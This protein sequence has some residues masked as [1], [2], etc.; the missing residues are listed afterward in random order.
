M[1]TM[2]F[3]EVCQSRDD[4]HRPEHRRGEHFGVGGGKGRSHRWEVIFNRPLTIE[5]RAI[6]RTGFVLSVINTLRDLDQQLL[7]RISEAG[8]PQLTIKYKWSGDLL[9]IH[10][11]DQWG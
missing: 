9:E 7:R 10:N 2:S 5:E 4:P 8:M 11:R 3:C 6:L 1:A